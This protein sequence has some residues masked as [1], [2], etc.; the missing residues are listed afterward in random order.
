[1]TNSKPQGSALYTSLEASCH[2]KHS[3]VVWRSLPSPATRLPS[4]VDVP[5]EGSPGLPEVWGPGR[6]GSPNEKLRY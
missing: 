4:P 2:V 6:Q 3:E 1:M 5:K